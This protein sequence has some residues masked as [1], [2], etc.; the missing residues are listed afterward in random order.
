MPGTSAADPRNTSRKGA[1]MNARR[2][3]IPLDGSKTAEA[4]I[5]EAVQMA[6]G[7]PYTLLLVR[8]AHARVLPG[9][10]VV[11]DWVDAVREA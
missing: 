10:D 9:A 3:L 7:G 4:A 1:V 5:P 6:G 8:V 2:I 11:G